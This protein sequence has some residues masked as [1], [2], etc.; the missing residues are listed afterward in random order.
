M[1]NTRFDQFIG[2]RDRQGQIALIG[3]SQQGG[4]KPEGRLLTLRAGQAIQKSRKEANPFRPPAGKGSL[5]CATLEV[6]PHGG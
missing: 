5:L 4:R 2:N 3:P 1:G 6:V